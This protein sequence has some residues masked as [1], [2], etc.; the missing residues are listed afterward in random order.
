[1]TPNQ[2]WS[3]R[4]RNLFFNSK[5]NNFKIREDLSKRNSNA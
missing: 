4:S 5:M 2:K 1:M 3:A